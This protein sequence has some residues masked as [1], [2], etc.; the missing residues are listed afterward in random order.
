LRDTHLQGDLP[1]PE[2]QAVQSGRK[3]GQ[4]WQEE[5]RLGGPRMRL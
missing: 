1:L 5:R 3:R 2:A 4:G